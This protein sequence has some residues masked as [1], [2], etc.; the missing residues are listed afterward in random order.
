MVGSDA[1][2]CVARTFVP[3]PA[4]EEEAPWNIPMVRPVT[5]RSAN[6]TKLDVPLPQ[7]FADAFQRLVTLR[8]QRAE[9]GQKR[10]FYARDLH[11]EAIRE[12]IQRAEGKANLL[13]LSPPACQVRKTLYMDEGL[14]D[15]ITRL[16]EAHQVSRSAVVVTAFH[17]YLERNGA[18]SR[19]AA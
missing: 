18:L 2:C 7:G 1:A 12:L 6:A 9:P 13:F 14:R 4:F 15:G 10:R 8:N 5:E 19:V 3:A 11:E 16:A 17:S